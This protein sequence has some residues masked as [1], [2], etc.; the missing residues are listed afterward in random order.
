MTGTSL[1]RMNTKNITLAVV[2]ALQ[3][4]FAV[5]NAGAQIADPVVTVT[6]GASQQTITATVTESTGGATL[7]Y[8]MDGSA[9]TLSSPSIASGGSVL[10]SEN[11]N[12]NV[13]AFTSS[14]TTSNLVT[15][16]YNQAGQVSAG[17][18]HSLALRNDGTVWA[19][20]DNTYGELGNGTTNNSSTPLQVS[21]LSGIVAVA[22]GQDESFAVD[23][24]GNVWAWG[25]NPNGQ[26]GMSST[27]S[28]VTVPTQVTT[29][30]GIVAIASAGYHT[31]ALQTNGSVWAFGAD[32]S[33]QVGNGTTGSVVTPPVQLTTLQGIVAIAAGTNHSLALDN[34][35]KVWAWGSNTY[36]QLGLGSYAEQTLP[37]QVGSSLTGVISIA[38][39][40]ED[41]YAVEGNGT[42]W[43]WGDNSIGELGNGTTT[44][45]NTPTQVNSSTG[46]IAAISNQT[47]VA[48]TGQVYSWGDNTD[49][50]L[51]TGSGSPYVT[52]PQIVGG[53]GIPAASFWT[54]VTLA[55]ALLVVMARKVSPRKP[56]A[57]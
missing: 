18:R 36:G 56:V 54:L 10:V 44:S 32:S 45:S 48:S 23:S 49:G 17:T 31:L 7:H 29:L 20:G 55:A 37:V 9:P 40:V 13:Q 14:T 46:S 28:S 12:L 5:S 26:L 30:S 25:Y 47:S 38:A 24:S 27:T 50:R 41:S 22:A 2:L 42:A 3:A 51:G 21:G 33:G 11:A 8:T 4:V 19:C 53:T 6:G 34:T 57:A 52:L 1:N 35:G 43:A 15:T 16:Q 39:G